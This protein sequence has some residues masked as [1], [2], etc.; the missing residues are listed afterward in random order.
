MKETSPYT[1][2]ERFLDHWDGVRLVTLELLKCFE[3]EELP[4]RYIPS[5]RTVGELFHHIGAHQFYATRGVLKRRW[6]PE[7]GEPDE[8]WDE[9]KKRVTTSIVDLHQWLSNVQNLVKQWFTEADE[10]ILF[11]I[12]ENN[13]WHEG[14]RGWLLLHHAYQD[15]VH[16][17]GQLYTIVRQ[18][19]R[20]PPEVFAEEYPSYWNSRKGK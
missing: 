2:V 4:L 7:D 18:L 5:W 12:Q 1:T 16:H 14:I 10:D 15:E 6:A 19:N 13:P 8:D 11:E 17:R 3:D 20:N 9:H